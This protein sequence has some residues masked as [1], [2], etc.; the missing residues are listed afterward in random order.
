M[1]Y[2]QEDIPQTDSNGVVKAN[3]TILERSE[4][5]AGSNG[6]QIPIPQETGQN[7]SATT[8]S[9]TQLVQRSIPPIQAHV[10][11]GN[12]TSHQSTPQHTTGSSIVTVYATPSNKPQTESVSDLNHDD[13]RDFESIPSEGI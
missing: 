3:K 5:N 10:E 13:L 4:K 8:S 2:T 1:D 6:S 12:L 9:R 11:L 7:G